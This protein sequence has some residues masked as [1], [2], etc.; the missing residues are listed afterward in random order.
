MS[1]GGYAMG[2]SSLRR[3]GSSVAMDVEVDMTDSVRERR[4]WTEYSL[5][6]AEDVLSVDE[7]ARLRAFGAPVSHPHGVLSEQK[8]GGVHRRDV[9][10]SGSVLSSYCIRVKLR[11]QL[12]R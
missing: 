12:N 5:S 11:V 8:V 10:Q 6:G 7:L 3:L 1:T 2:V 9:F 4:P